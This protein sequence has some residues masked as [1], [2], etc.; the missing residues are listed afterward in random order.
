MQILRLLITVSIFA[1]CSALAMD[2]QVHHAHV[3][4]VPPT[5]AVTAAFMEIHNTGDK[6]R[7]LVS[8][9]SAVADAVELHTHT[10][11]EGV[12][13]M[14]QVEQIDLPA[15]SITL[16]QPGGLH[17]MLIGL[18]KPLKVDD[19]VLVSLKL[20]DGSLIELNLPVR[21]LEP[22]SHMKGRMKGHIKGHHH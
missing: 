15:D 1:S 6:S 14:R 20:D 8:A 16:L 17:I 12:M 3:R 9:N 5:A 7:A 2:I 13:Q 22:S 4:A 18:K 19:K 11:V 10:K 21:K